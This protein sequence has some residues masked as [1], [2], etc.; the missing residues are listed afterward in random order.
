MNYSNSK[1]NS[2]TPNDFDVLRAFI[3]EI[4]S[5]IRRKQKIFLFFKKLQKIFTQRLSSETE[6]A[7]I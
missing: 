5:S 2:V 6:Q 3:L 1:I 4:H 7:V